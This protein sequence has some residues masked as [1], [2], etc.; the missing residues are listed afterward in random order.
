MGVLL[1]LTKHSWAEITQQVSSPFVNQKLVSLQSSFRVYDLLANSAAHSFLCVVNDFLIVCYLSWVGFLVRWL[2]VNLVV[3]LQL[4]FLAKAFVTQ[5]AR[6]EAHLLMNSD[7]VTIETRLLSEGFVTDSTNMRPD[8]LMNHLN[9]R[10]E[11]D[12][13]L[14]T[15]HAFL[16]SFDA[17][18]SQMRVEVASRLEE[19][20]A[21]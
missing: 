7:N 16:R 6:P 21:N 14:V 4:S 12:E 2:E 10:T 3:S 13:D 18:S 15:I 19:L 11:I 17:V 8:L 5:I 9:V 20:T 1:K